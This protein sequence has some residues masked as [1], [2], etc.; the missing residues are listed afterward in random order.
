MDLT[1]IQNL[2]IKIVHYGFFNLISL[3]LINLRFLILFSAIGSLLIVV[4]LYFVLWGKNR[5]V[6]KNDGVGEITEEV[7]DDVK[8]LELQP[9]DPFNGDRNHHDGDD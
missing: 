8:D 2:P 3:F 9:C 7:K 1:Q 6:N 5:E 4:G